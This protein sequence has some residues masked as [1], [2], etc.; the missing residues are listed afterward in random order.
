[1]VRLVMWGLVGLFSFILKIQR[2]LRAFLLLDLLCLF[3]RLARCGPRHV[4]RF[5]FEQLFH[6]DDLDAWKILLP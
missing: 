4:D 3:E 2:A 5:A 1:M 6:G